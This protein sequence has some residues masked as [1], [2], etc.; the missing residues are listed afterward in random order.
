MIET[1]ILVC[2]SVVVVVIISHF[3]YKNKYMGAKAEIESKSANI[4]AIISAEIA[5]IRVL[6]FTAPTS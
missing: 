2:V 3:Y 4:E 5:D 6:S 1:I